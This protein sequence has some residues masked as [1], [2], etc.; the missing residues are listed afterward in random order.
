[1]IIIIISLSGGY[2]LA[3]SH[4][5][6]SCVSNVIITMSGMIITDLIFGRPILTAIT[7][8]RIIISSIVAW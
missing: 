5:I 7:N 8:E 6:A 3:H 1:M 2:Q 4:P